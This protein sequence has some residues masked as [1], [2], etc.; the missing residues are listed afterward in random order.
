VVRKYVPTTTSTDE[1]SRRGVTFSFRNKLDIMDAHTGEEAL[2]DVA[3][4]A[5]IRFMLS[6]KMIPPRTM[7]KNP[8][9]KINSRDFLSRFHFFVGFDIMS[10]KRDKAG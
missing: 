8:E 5:P 3:L 6:K 2:R 10:M 7:P 1:I 9:A 4:E